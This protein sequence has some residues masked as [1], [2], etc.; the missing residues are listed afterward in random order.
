MMKV[1]TICTLSF[2]SKGR[3]FCLFDLVMFSIILTLTSFHLFKIFQ[4]SLYL[5][6]SFVQNL[7]LFSLCLIFFFLVSHISAK[8]LAFET[9]NPKKF[10]WFFAFENSNEAI[11]LF[12][13]HIFLY[14]S[15]FLK[16]RS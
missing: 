11:L 13:F 15:L 10:R 12:D 16:L 3:I 4:P 14:I 8:S 5:S 2:H 7:Q 9:G 6:I 1:G